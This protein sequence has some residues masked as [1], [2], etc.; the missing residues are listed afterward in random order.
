MLSEKEIREHIANGAQK[1]PYCGSGNF[2]TKR[3][4]QTIPKVGQGVSQIPH[5]T[6]FIKLPQQCHCGNT[7]NDIYQLVDLEETT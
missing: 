1:C 2:S 6:T 5:L 7:W 4:I 3:A